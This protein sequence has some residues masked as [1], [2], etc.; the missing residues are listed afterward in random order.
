MNKRLAKLKNIQE[1]NIAFLN[2]NSKETLNERN[3]PKFDSDDDD[4]EWNDDDYYNDDDKF[5]NDDEVWAR[6][7]DDEEEESY[8]PGDRD[9]HYKSHSDYSTEP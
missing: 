4:K 5:L 1:A 9:N 8:D 2:R 6:D 7:D 3:V